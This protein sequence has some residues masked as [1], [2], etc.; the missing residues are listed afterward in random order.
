LK[1]QVLKAIQSPQHTLELLES[2]ATNVLGV[3][4]TA[5]RVGRLDDLPLQLRRHVGVGPGKQY[6]WFAWSV[7]ER[8]ALVT[9]TLSLE[10][11]RERGQPVLEVR[12][13]DAEGLLDEAA[14]WV[15]TGTTEWA[16]S[17]W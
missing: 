8:V 7:D 16:R 4:A 9:G 13:Y 15:N 2:F 14:T 1:T 3:P 10:Q 6:V 17:Q 5:Q 12:S 11:S